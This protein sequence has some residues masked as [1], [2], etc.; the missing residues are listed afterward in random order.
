MELLQY[1][2]EEGLIMIPALY[3]LGEIIKDTELLNNKWIPI[4]LLIISVILTP[5]VISGYTPDNIIQAVL[6][7]GVTVYG[8]QMVKQLQKGE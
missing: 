6:I 8:D 2:V 5:I 4:V 7:T 1:I 3:I